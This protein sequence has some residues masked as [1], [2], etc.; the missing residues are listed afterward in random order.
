MH[1]SF[2]LLL[3]FLMIAV[4]SI[5]LHA[6]DVAPVDPEEPTPEE[7]PDP[8]KDD[9]A[10]DKVAPRLLPPQSAVL[11]LKRWHDAALCSSCKGTGKATK[12]VVTGTRTV[13][14][15]KAGFPI[16]QNITKEVTVDCAACDGERLTKDKRLIAGGNTFARTL[17]Q[18]DITD[19]RWP[20]AHDDLL[21]NLREL[22]DLGKAAWR[23]RLNKTIGVL[24]TGTVIKNAQP[25]VFVG[26]LDQER[27]KNETGK[28]VLWVSVGN[29]SVR[30]EKPRLVDSSGLGQVFPL[31]M[32]CGGWL[33]RREDDG[34][35]FVSVIENGFVMSIR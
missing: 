35:R 14:P 24:L 4:G 33:V 2:K 23:S 18:I 27:Q 10:D 21:T 32:L 6:A 30:F 29:T 3:A 34:G 17:A 9:G 5:H 31:S 8:A 16:K 11:A 22:V 26:Y 12:T 13:K 19:E 20:A 28:R 7:H 15:D 25:I 1:T